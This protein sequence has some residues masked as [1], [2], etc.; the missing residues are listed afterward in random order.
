MGM[1]VFLFCK[2][3]KRLN[4]IKKLS[5]IYTKKTRS[6]EQ[7]SFWWIIALSKQALQGPRD[8]AVH[9]LQSGLSGISMCCKLSGAASTECNLEAISISIAFFHWHRLNLECDLAVIGLQVPKLLRSRKKGKKDRGVS[10]NGCALVCAFT[11]TPPLFWAAVKVLLSNSKYQMT[12]FFKC[13]YLW[14]S[15]GQHLWKC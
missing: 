9:V 13:Q 6:P 12:D 4:F 15:L 14:T 8:V 3:L 5:L 10:K 2:L 11:P 7:T 1:I